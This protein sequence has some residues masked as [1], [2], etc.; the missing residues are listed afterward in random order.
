MSE[1]SKRTFSLWFLFILCV[2]PAIFL[3]PMMLNGDLELSRLTVLYFAFV[4]ASAVFLIAAVL[5]S[6]SAKAA[7]KPAKAPPETRGYDPGRRK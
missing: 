6:V 7:R 2:V 3:T 1:K 5:S 4:T